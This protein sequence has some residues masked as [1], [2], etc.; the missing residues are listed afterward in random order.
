MAGYY[1][2]DK[3]PNGTAH[4]ANATAMGTM[5]HPMTHYGNT[6]EFLV[7]GWPYIG[8]KTNSTGST[9]SFTVDFDYVTQ[10]VQVSAIGQDITI[11]IGTGSA[12]FIVPEDRTVKLPVKLKTIKFSIPNTGTVSFCA[13]LTN[14]PASEFPDI[15]AFDGIAANPT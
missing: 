13:G 8:S 2:R 12:T 4:K 11:S 6:A 5:N 14:V 15:S 9:I 3:N 7:A 1:D 10:F